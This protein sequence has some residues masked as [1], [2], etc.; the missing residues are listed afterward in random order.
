MVAGVRVKDIDWEMLK[1]LDASIA[2]DARHVKRIGFLATHQ[3]DFW[4]KENL[5]DKDAGKQFLE[6][7]STRLLGGF[8]Y[9]VTTLTINDPPDMNGNSFTQLFYL[10]Y[11]AALNS[12]NLGIVKHTTITR[13]LESTDLN[14]KLRTLYAEDR[15]GISA[16]TDE[17]Y[18]KVVNLMHFATDSTYK[19][20]EPDD[21]ASY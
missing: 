14:P 17:D 18:E 5:A 1:E 20:M 8:A 4:A 12:S 21:P 7:G 6:W 11:P 10:N 15:A 19:V 3:Y 13:P 9:R 2:A 16:I